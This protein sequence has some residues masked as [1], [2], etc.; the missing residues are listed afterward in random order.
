[1]KNTLLTLLLLI[2]ASPSIAAHNL[3]E[4]ALDQPIIGE[5]FYIPFY[6]SFVTPHLESNF[7]E[8]AFCHS[9]IEKSKFQTLIIESQK[10]YHA[11]PRVKI[12]F[13]DDVYYIDQYG[14]ISNTTA[15]T[16][17]FELTD[18]EEFIQSIQPLQDCLS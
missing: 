17:T 4:T 8:M 10:Q 2:A 6:M 18:I 1:M 7:E 5:G 15:P 13:N 14:V 3:N 12:K 9:Q 11:D 16:H